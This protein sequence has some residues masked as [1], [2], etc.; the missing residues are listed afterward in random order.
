MTMQ[1]KRGISIRGVE[2]ISIDAHTARVIE[3]GVPTTY[4]THEIVASASEVFVEEPLYTTEMRLTLH[5]KD[6]PLPYDAQQ[7]KKPHIRT[8]SDAVRVIRSVNDLIKQ[9]GQNFL[10]DMSSLKARRNI[11]QIN[12][13][14]FK[15]GISSCDIPI[16]L[17]VV[18]SCDSQYIPPKVSS[19]LYGMHIYT[20]YK[21]MKGLAED[22]IKQYPDYVDGYTLQM[23]RVFKTH[24]VNMYLSEEAQNYM[25]ALHPLLDAASKQN[26]F[27]YSLNPKY[28]YEYFGGQCDCKFFMSKEWIRI[29]QKINRIKT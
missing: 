16:T 20:V 7:T 4:Q 3:K 12:P 11:L 8:L 17:H 28:I 22:L 9:N 2:I 19:I 6:R 14:K 10:F 1:K 26:G 24:H 21:Q 29:A 5:T 27:K 13:A 15:K 25:R 23:H 18:Q